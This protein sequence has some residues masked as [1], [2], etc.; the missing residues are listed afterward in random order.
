MRGVITDV[1]ERETKTVAERDV[2]LEET[3][4][5]VDVF[6]TRP[7]VGF[8]R[9]NRMWHPYRPSAIDIVVP[10]A[11]LEPVVVEVQSVCK[12]PEPCLCFLIVLTSALPGDVARDEHEVG[13][14][15]KTVGRLQKL[16]QGDLS[17]SQS[18]RRPLAVGLY[19]EVEIG[20][21]KDSRQEGSGLIQPPSG[22]EGV[23]ARAYQDGNAGRLAI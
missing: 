19:S 17:L 11:E 4:E 1:Q 22:I 7:L 23:A 8:T 5:L 16:P 6:Y 14:R 18:R 3:R 20:Q 10:N 15:I 12:V 2:S 13:S 9:V 21:V